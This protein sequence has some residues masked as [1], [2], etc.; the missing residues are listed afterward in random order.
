M[1]QAIGLVI[2]NHMLGCRIEAQRP[3]KAVRCVR[4]MD[5]RAGNV[6]FLNGRSQVLFPSAAN[7]LDKVREVIAPAMPVRP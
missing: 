2:V 5:Q 1:Q 4:Q 3:P 7:T 6:S